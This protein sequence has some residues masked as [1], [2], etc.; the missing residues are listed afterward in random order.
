MT[1][2]TK[3]DAIIAL[4]SFVDLI[5]DNWRESIATI[6]PEYGYQNELN[7]DTANN[8]K[9]EFRALLNAVLSAE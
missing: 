1:L 5:V 7:E 4:I 6:D 3:N 2:Q 8:V 9:E